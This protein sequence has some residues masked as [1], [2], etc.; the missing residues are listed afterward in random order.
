M[1]KVAEINLERGL[2]SVDAAVQTMKDALTA[3]S[4]RGAGAAV[5][6]HG[7]G[8]SGVGGGVRAAVRR[9]L[10]E[11]GMKGVVRDFVGGEQWHWRRKEFIS[12]CRD[13]AAYEGRIANNEGV[14]IVILK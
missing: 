14:T 10:G 5:L 12:V 13:L 6:I 3:C 1:Q 8:S 4:R 11:G 9:C 7:Y 2:P